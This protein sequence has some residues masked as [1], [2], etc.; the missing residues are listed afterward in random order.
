VQNLAWSATEEALRKEFG[1]HGELD[2]DNT[3][4]ILNR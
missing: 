3:K 1:K 4:I 2:L